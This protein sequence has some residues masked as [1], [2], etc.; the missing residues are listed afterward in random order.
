M[1]RW[2]RKM[3]KKLLYKILFRG[4]VELLTEILKLLTSNPGKKNGRD[5]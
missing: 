5:K 1:W 3:L 4:L 2:A